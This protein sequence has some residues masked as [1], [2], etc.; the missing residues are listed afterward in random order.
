MTAP[1]CVVVFPFSTRKQG[2]SSVNS[3]LGMSILASPWRQLPLIVHTN[4][5]RHFS[6]YSPDLPA[7]NIAWCIINESRPRFI[8]LHA[9]VMMEVN[10]WKTC[11]VAAHEDRMAL[12]CGVMRQIGIR[13]VG[14][15]SV[16][17]YDDKAQEFW[18]RNQLRFRLWHRFIEASHYRRKGWIVTPEWMD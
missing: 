2:P 15:I 4:I 9:L 12:C 5:A 16:D 6:F 14:E 1:D 10:R 11:V 3:M 13:V 7:P 18:M 17:S 8:A